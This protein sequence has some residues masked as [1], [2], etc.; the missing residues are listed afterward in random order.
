M[1]QLLHVAKC[2]RLPYRIIPKVSNVNSRFKSDKCQ[3]DGDKNKNKETKE[4]KC[5]AAKK[6]ETAISGGAKCG[7]K[8]KETGPKCPPCSCPSKTSSGHHAN[9]WKKIT[10]MGVL[11]IVAILTVLVFTSHHEGERPEFKPWPHLYRRT[12]SFYF[13]DGN[14]TMFHN[15]HWNPLPPEGYEDETDL[16]AEGKPAETAQER[17]QR[18]KEFGTV[19]KEWK[20][21]ASKREAEAKKAEAAA[22]KEAK[23][24]QAEADK[25]EKRQRAEAEK[26][27]KRQ[28]AEEKKQRAA[29]EKE[30]KRLEAEEK[31][32]Q[33]EEAKAQKV[34][35]VFEKEPYDLRDE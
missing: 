1:L 17:D 6:D 34:E 20:K 29:E 22:E 32:R 31:K 14:R 4:T 18:L 10:F 5:Q 9:F 30:R 11:P 12:K 13:G 25:E 15:P 27:R 35:Y 21:L 19:H 24:L 8:K 7:S 26:E 16:D 23:R 33:K 2:F 28:E 3:K